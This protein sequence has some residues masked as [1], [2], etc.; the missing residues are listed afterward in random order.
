[1]LRFPAA[2][3]QSQCR[4]RK[5]YVVDTL[6][7]AAGK[8]PSVDEGYVHQYQQEN[9]KLAKYAGVAL[10]SSTKVL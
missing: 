6:P 4:S 8:W 2:P 9:K 10:S 5:P 7:G 3:E 1:M